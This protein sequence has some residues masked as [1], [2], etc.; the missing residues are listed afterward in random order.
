MLLMEIR[1]P[2]KVLDPGGPTDESEGIFPSKAKR[3]DHKDSERIRAR[4]K[5]GYSAM[6]GEAPCI[7][8]CLQGLWTCTNRGKNVNRR[9]PG[10]P[11]FARMPHVETK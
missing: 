10:L 3:A 1:L 5:S 9:S 2:L 6:V 4:M 8:P 11:A 7:S